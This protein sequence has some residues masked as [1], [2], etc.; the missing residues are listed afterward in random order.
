[1]NY[2][3]TF[4]VFTPTYNRAHTLHRV[5]ASLCAQTFRDFEWLV[6]DDGSTDGTEALVKGWQADADFPIRYIWKE[7][8]GRHTAYNVGIAEAHGC[9]FVIIDSDDECIP[10]ALERMLAFWESIAEARRGE[11]ALVRVLCSTSDGKVLGDRFP[12]DVFD[13]NTPEL[14]YRYRLRGDKF[15][16][17]LTDVLRAYPF[18]VLSVKVRHIPEALIAMEFG[19]RYLARCVNESLMIV[20]LESDSLS[21]PASSIAIAKQIAPAFALYHRK[22][23]NEEGHYAWVAPLLLLRAATHYVRFSM[24]L[25][26]SVTRQWRQLYNVRAHVIYLFGL[27]PGLL[28][29]LRD[30]LLA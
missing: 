20:H 3:Y 9:F 12:M 23:L 17:V 28:V 25:G 15:G 4:T 7:N 21:R 2:A 16:F 24:H 5:Y 19:K 13:V 30:R 8:G 27:V 18:P 11:F 10:V 6:V 1:M 14:Q 26:H 22:V 29:F